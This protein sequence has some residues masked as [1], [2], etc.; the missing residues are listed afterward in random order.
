[1]TA[2]NPCGSATEYYVMNAAGVTPTR[3]LVSGFACSPL[4]TWAYKITV[5]GIVFDGYP[6][7][8]GTGAVAPF[9]RWQ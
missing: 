6:I 7:A 8:A 1:M 2:A 5:D 3:V 9:Y 4:T